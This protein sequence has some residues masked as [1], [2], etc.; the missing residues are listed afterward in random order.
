[1]PIAAIWKFASS[2][3]GIAIIAAIVIGGMTLY[4][5]VLRGD[6][7]LLKERETRWAD[8]I[9]TLE[10]GIESEKAL[11]VTNSELRASDQKITLDLANSLATER[12]ITDRLQGEL[13][14]LHA[15]EE[16]NALVDP[17][18]RADAASDRIGRS[19]QRLTRDSEVHNNPDGRPTTADDPASPDDQRDQGSED[20]DV[21]SGGN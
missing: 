15:T 1:M 3:V 16:R 5:Q 8:Q 21:D 4:I 6:V 17:F 10:Q 11:A 7:D 12:L 13:N 2:R 18:G 9:K 19:L 14:E 20:A